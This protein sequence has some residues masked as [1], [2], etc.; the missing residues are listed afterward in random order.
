MESSYFSS[1]NLIVQVADLDLAKTRV[2]ECLQL[3]GDMMD[4]SMCSEV[5]NLP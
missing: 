3:A 1:M 4:L 2:V 5:R